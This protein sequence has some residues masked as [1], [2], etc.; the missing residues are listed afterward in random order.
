[1]RHSMLYWIYWWYTRQIS[2]KDQKVGTMIKSNPLNWL[3]SRAKTKVFV[4]QPGN[5]LQWQKQETTPQTEAQYSFYAE[6][7]L[8][9]KQGETLSFCL[10]SFCSLVSWNL[11]NKIMWSSLGKLSWAKLIAKLI[12]L[13]LRRRY[14]FLSYT[15][16]LTEGIFKSF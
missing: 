2:T 10:L 5:F 3:H 14:R 16:V 8:S 6:L 12:G 4:L 9:Q 13:R 11:W 7:G 1:M 15:F